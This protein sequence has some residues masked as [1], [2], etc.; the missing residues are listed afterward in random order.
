[1]Y[2]RDKNHPS[3]TMWSL[4][5]ESGG[6]RCQDA[7]CDF[8]KKVNPEIPVHYEA[9]IRTKRWAYD[10]ISRMYAYPELMRGI[11]EGK[12]KKYK[13]KPFFQ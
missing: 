8:L 13:C 11:L 10:V 3:I 6:Y 4:G 12:E 1:M 5:N 7:C 2:E 9:V